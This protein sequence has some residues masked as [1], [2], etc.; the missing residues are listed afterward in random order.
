MK[1]RKV[2]FVLAC[3]LMITSINIC[4]QQNNQ[5]LYLYRNDG[6]FN[7]FFLNEVDSIVYSQYDLDSVMYDY[8]VVQEIHTT[9]SVYRILLQNI[10]SVGFVQPPVVFNEHVI[11][12]D[13][14]LYDYLT[15]V[16]EMNLT[17]SKFIPQS[18]IPAV[19]DVL[20]SEK[21]DDLYFNE[22]FAGKVSVVSN[23][24]GY[25]NISCDSIDDITDIYEK[26]IYV[27]ELGENVNNVKSKVR[28]TW[29]LP[30]IPLEFSLDY[31][32]P[33]IAGIDGKLYGALNADLKGKVIYDINKE[34]Q[35]LKLE[36]YH[37]WYISAGMELELKKSYETDINKKNLSPSIPLPYCPFLK[38]QFKGAPFLKIEGN[39]EAYMKYVG[40]KHSYR[41]DLSYDSGMF[42]A[43]NVRL[44]NNGNGDN[45][46]HFESGFSIN[47]S[48][49]AGF[50]LQLYLGTVEY[51]KNKIY[52]AADFYVGPKLSGDISCDIASNELFEVYSAF[53]DSN[54]KFDILSME[55][56][57]SGN[58][59]ILGEKVFSKTFYH[60]EF[61]SP[62]TRK[63]Y[64][65]PEFEKPVVVK[66]N[67]NI[68]VTCEPKRNLLFPVQLGFALYENDCQ[69]DS[70]FVDLPYRLKSKWNNSAFTEVFKDFTYNSDYK[71]YP[72][73]RL[74]DMDILAEPSE[75][76]RFEIK[77][78]NLKTDD[79]DY[80]GATLLAEIKGDFEALD[81][82]STR[83]GFDLWY[84]GCREEE[85]RHIY[86]QQ[87]HGLICSKVDDLLAG[88]NYYYRPFVELSDTI[89]VG[90][91]KSFKTKMPVE[92]TKFEKSIGIYYPDNFTYNEDVY[93]FRYNGTVYMKAY[94]TNNVE[95]WGYVVVEPDGSWRHKGLA[96]YGRTN[97][98]DPS[99]ST[100]SNNTSTY[101]EFIPYVKYANLNNVVYG[102]KVVFPVEYTEDV[103]VKFTRCEF[104]GTEN[105]LSYNGKNYDFCS[106]FKFYFN[107]EG[108]YWLNVS[109]A[110]EGSGWESWSMIPD[111]SMH[112]AD[113]ENIMTV[114][115][116]YNK[117]DVK[118]KYAV[119]LYVSDNKHGLNF[120]SDEYVILNYD[121]GCFNGCTFYKSNNE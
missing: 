34:R 15:D 14:G 44:R 18:M 93:S 65:F 20:I 6:D 50:D 63:W 118:G 60:Q 92:I 66:R 17:F 38:L 86:T 24:D 100:F 98:A 46:P 68:L 7:A 111:T 40:E 58:A 27:G 80:S 9:D 26:L 89:I 42:K 85:I 12:I 106:T 21:Y 62:F 28:D 97:I 31:K 78:D 11:N 103:A 39:A 75:D 57:V 83:F 8:D 71:C 30:V 59:D 112:P 91:K 25:I 51:L 107:A 81:M 119:R 99:I 54:V 94:N 19:G 49:Y 113:G 87:S 47:G 56:V 88:L 64:L 61:D 117:S 33:K 32:L 16:K 104:V 53:K 79:I 10:D 22:G 102:E 48:I 3:I 108:A 101:I 121:G 90:N 29:N 36:L 70:S 55:M 73:I 35:F 67:G 76:V 1:G 109:T 110:S 41:Y 4:A 74:F 45:S 114:N 69:V 2:S 77:F 37:D 52:S 96:K 115:Y 120:K 5:A 95:D 105:N 72:M 23:K 82:N 116:Y 13:D 43:N 84:E